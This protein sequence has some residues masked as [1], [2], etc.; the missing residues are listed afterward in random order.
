MIEI[1]YTKLEPRSQTQPCSRS[2]RGVSVSDG[3]KRLFLSQED[4]NNGATLLIGCDFYR[5]FTS[6]GR[7][8]RLE[9]CRCPWT[10]CDSFFSYR[11]ICLGGSAYPFYFFFNLCQGEG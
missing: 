5:F 11:L 9:S 6:F 2:Q 3:Q 7:L 8:F 4:E 10:P 1:M